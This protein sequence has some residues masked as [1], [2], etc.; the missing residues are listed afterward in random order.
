GL[1]TAT[2]R[3]SGR[4]R[5]VLPYAV[6][7]APVSSTKRRFTPGRLRNSM[8]AMRG[9]MA[10]A[11]VAAGGCGSGSESPSPA[12]RARKPGVRASTD[13]LH[14]LGGVPAGWKLAPPPG[15]VDA[16][17]RAFVDFGCHSC[18]LVKGEAFAAKANATG[19]Q[20][21]PELTGMG[22]HHPPAYFAEAIMSPD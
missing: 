11:L 14:G 22:L 18:H 19:M 10:V 4:D 1:D 20:V 7:R 3:R 21:G 16:G 6:G 5:H 13:Q 8:T 15:D 17:R 9:I 12:A 2:T